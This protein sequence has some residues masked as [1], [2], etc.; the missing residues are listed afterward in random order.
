M[1]KKKNVKY[2]FYHSGIQTSVL[3]DPTTGTITG[4]NFAYNP[5][6]IDIS[7]GGVY[8]PPIGDASTINPD[9]TDPAGTTPTPVTVR[10]DGEPLGASKT[11]A[12]IGTGKSSDG[13]SK[14]QTAATAATA[15]T[16]SNEKSFWDERSTEILAG[17]GITAAVGAGAAYDL[18]RKKGKSRIKRLYNASRTEAENVFNEFSRSIRGNNENMKELLARDFSRNGPLYQAWQ[19]NSLTLGVNRDEWLVGGRQYTQANFP[20][21]T[22]PGFAMIRKETTVFLVNEATGQ[23]F[24]EDEVKLR[25]NNNSWVSPKAVE[26][27]AKT[28]QNPTGIKVMS[29]VNE[30]GNTITL[31]RVLRGEYNESLGN[32]PENQRDGVRYVE[33]PTIKE[34]DKSDTAE[35]LRAASSQRRLIEQQ[36]AN[37]GSTRSQ[38][39]ILNRI[40]SEEAR[41]VRQRESDERQIEA[42]AEREVARKAAEVKTAAD[43]RIAISDITAMLGRAVADTQVDKN[44]YDIDSQWVERFVSSGLGNM[45]PTDKIK[46]WTYEMGTGGQELVVTYTDEWAAERGLALGEERWTRDSLIEIN[47]IPKQYGPSMVPLW[48]T[49]RGTSNVGPAWAQNS[50]RNVTL[51][52]GSMGGG[53]MGG[54]GAL[55][56]IRSRLYGRQ[57]PKGHTTLNRTM[58]EPL[59]GLIRGE[60]LSRKI[61]DERFSVIGSTSGLRHM[62]KPNARM[63]A[64]Q[65][66]QAGYKA[67]VIPN[68]KGYRVY[69]GPRRAR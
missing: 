13:I 8:I 49:N 11:V 24:T 36:L 1:A 38:N 60:S 35:E 39:E 58:F 5:D 6:G 55:E 16:S 62:P 37:L 45:V 63:L 41:T 68:S 51:G 17:L 61:G 48:Q 21:T 33:K 59:S 31:K 29:V 19:S 7:G 50:K 46:S 27:E 15:A 20:R 18:T 30:R 10:I 69:L 26:T 40:D 12:R 64:N 47:G 42:Q 56:S 43:K 54:G 25:G 44:R 3:I 57:M 34:A 66:R 23:V 2:N 14:N 65:F 32:T 53:S 28:R 52:R 4:T 22:N 67:R 9:S